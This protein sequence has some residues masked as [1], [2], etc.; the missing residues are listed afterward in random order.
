MPGMSGIEAAERIRSFERCGQGMMLQRRLPIVG[1]T[2]QNLQSTSNIQQYLDAGM[3]DFL[4]FPVDREN[5][6][7]KV[8]LA[9]GTRPR[10]SWRAT[11][12]RGPHAPSP[13]LA[14]RPRSSIHAQ[15]LPA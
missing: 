1:M 4:T 5:L 15:P 8:R 12:L 10:P 7:L 14:S 2:A 11:A 9:D 13:A 6:L 3:D